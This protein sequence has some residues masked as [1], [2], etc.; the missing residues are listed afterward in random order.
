MHNLDHIQ[1][2][3]RALPDE[4]PRPPAKPPHEPL[5]IKI[6][7]RDT[8]IPEPWPSPPPD[9]PEIDNDGEAPAIPPTWP[10]ST[11]PDRP[12]LTNVAALRRKLR[13]G[14]EGWALDD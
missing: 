1:S 14:A 3:N 7:P 6:P 4:L 5:I 8:N 9:Q 12:S 11:P 2:Q 10:P 13:S